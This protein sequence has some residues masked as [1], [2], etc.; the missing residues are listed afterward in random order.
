MS[1]KG[2]HPNRRKTSKAGPKIGSGGGKKGLAGKGRTLKAE[3]RP[4]HKEY[5]GDDKP[6]KTQWKQ[7]KER[8]KAAAEGRTTNIG[9][10]RPTGRTQS[11]RRDDEPE[12]ILGRNPVL[13][14]LRAKVPATALYVA[15]GTE[16]DERVAESVRLAGNRDLPIKELAR[17][18]LDRRTNNAL[19]QGIGLQIEPYQYSEFEDLLEISRTSGTA[20]LL[21]A[22][23]GVTDPRNLGAIIRSA[24]AFG[25]HG[26][27]IPSKRAASVTAVAWRTSAGAAARLPV[28][29]V[30]NLTRTI[31]ACQQ[32]GFMTVA[33]DGGG[34]VDVFD[35]PVAN[36]PLLIVVGDEGKGVSRL[37]AETCDHR[38]G[39]PISSEVESLNASVAASIALAEV[40][41]QRR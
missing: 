20:P 18:D 37:V 19:H 12:L 38:A 28:A 40:Q 16:L 39:I 25:G 4:W 14:A 2:G 17:R 21:V 8:A 33:L 23:D 13:E 1:T 31:Q 35:L 26:L 6:R 5:Q 30:V 22:L 11:R 32:A 27:I 15:F 41:R 9:K 10:A 7:S 36:D 24:A 29:K 3:D 34:D